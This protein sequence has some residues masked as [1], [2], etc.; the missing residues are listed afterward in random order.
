MD[1]KHTHA[2]NTAFIQLFQKNLIY[3][4]KALVNWCNKLKSTVS[5][6]EVDNVV[7]KGPTDREIHGYN[8]P[9]RFGQMFSFAYKVCDS[10]E[11]IVVSTTMPETMLG[12]TAVAVHPADER[13]VFKA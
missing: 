13:Y 1:P 6:I 7:I 12:D 3:R 4:K 9:V 8:R 10:T 11:E 5:D 2:V